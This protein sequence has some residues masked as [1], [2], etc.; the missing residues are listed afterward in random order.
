[1]TLKLTQ[2]RRKWRIHWAIRHFVSVVSVVTASV[3]RGVSEILSLFRC[4]CLWP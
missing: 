1:V 4:D 3:S 2:G